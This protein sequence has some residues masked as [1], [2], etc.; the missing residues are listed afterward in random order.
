[1]KNYNLTEEDIIFVKKMIEFLQKKDCY[2][3]V[4]YWCRRLGHPNG[5]VYF[6]VGGSEPDYS[7][8]DC[9]EDLG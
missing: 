6:N 9:G 7:C 5:I 4:R 8:K 3:Q 1:M 2:S